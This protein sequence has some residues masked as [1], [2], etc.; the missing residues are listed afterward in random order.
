LVRVQVLRTAD[1]SPSIAVVRTLRDW[2]M[3]SAAGVEALVWDGRDDAGALVAPGTY[4]V[5]VQAFLDGVTL[6]NA[7]TG[8]VAAI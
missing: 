8:W 1:V 4:A 2:S 3:S 7:G 5:R 6:F